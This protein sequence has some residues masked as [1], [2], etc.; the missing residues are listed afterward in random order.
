M[1]NRLLPLSLLSTLLFSSI[2]HT[3]FAKEGMWRPA[4]LKKQEAEM[5][6]A[7]LQIPVTQ[8]YND[9]KPAL[10]DAVVIFGGG[11]TGEIVSPQGLIFTNHHCGYGAVQGVSSNEKNYLINGFWA[12]SN[13]EEIPC[14]GLSVTFIKKIEEVTKS[15]LSGIT[16]ETPEEER[17]KIIA[18]N[19]K[20]LEAGYKRALGFTAE[21]KPFYN[22]NEYWVT[23]LEKYDDVRLV[24][25]PPNGIGKFGGDTDNWMW[26]RQTGDFGIFRVYAGADNKPA[27]YSRNNKPYKASQYF[28]VNTSGVKEGDYTMV[29]GFPYVTREYLSS[30]QL[31]QTQDV[32]DPIRIAARKI[33][34]GVWDEAMRQ[35]PKTFLKYAS[36]QSS[37][38]NG[39]KK[40]QGEIRGLELNDVKSKKLA[41]ETR[42]MERSGED[43]NVNNPKNTLSQ[44]TAAVEH[45]NP[46][47]RAY[48]STNETVL[49]IEIVSQAAYLQRVLN[50]H[51]QHITGQALTDTLSKVKRG[52]SSFYKNYD[53]VLDKTLF[54]NLMPFYYMQPGIAVAPKIKSLFA[55]NGSD[56]GKWSGNVFGQSAL[57]LPQLAMHYFDSPKASDT[58]DI[59][60]DPAYKIYAAVT[61]WQ[62]KQVKPEMTAFSK[63]M[64]YLNRVYMQQQLKYMGKDRN[65]YPDANQTLR[66]T[67]GHVQGITPQGSSLYSYKSTLEDVIAKHNP[68]IEEFNVPVK[69]RDLYM[70]KD[71]GRWNVDGTVPVTFIASNHTSGGN[72][73]SPVLNAKGQLIGINFDRVWDGTMSDLYYD[74]NLCRNIAVDIRY[75]LFIIE[76]YGN[77]SWLFK[78]MNLVK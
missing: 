6:K 38:S 73:G 77:A 44:I 39:Y 35:D 34:L 68:D 16:E 52:L 58:I 57:A 59:K 65:F 14:P 2:T 15:V 69:L 47:L 46:Y 17:N 3:S 76:K 22:G 66:L 72:S 61:E 48:E 27:A 4:D 63:R 23:V 67:Y 62:D 71:Y 13:A 40:W 11:C 12:K 55:E 42:L 28:A 50:I 33:K 70:S 49:G 1:R 43:T 41:Y 7:G 64:D 19:I 45:N 9:G 10:N 26:P 54:E 18:S 20:F 36:K 24:G 8:L 25:F 5:K 21:V 31:A 60:N 32:I 30:A 75:V 29:Y 37:I 56:F 53:P 78:E 51:R 74:P